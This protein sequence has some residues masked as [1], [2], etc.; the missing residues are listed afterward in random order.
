MKSVLM[1]CIFI[2]MGNSMFSQSE[3]LKKA[4]LDFKTDY[5]SGDYEKIFNNFS[6]EMQKALPLENAVQFFNGLKFQA[7]TIKE[8]EVLKIGDN[9]YTVYKTTFEKIILAV[10]IAIDSQN[11]I[12]GL[13]I[14]PYL[15]ETQKKIHNGLKKYPQEIGTAIFKHAKSFPDGTQLS[16]AIIKDGKEKYYGVKLEKDTLKP[17]ENQHKVFEIGSITK[18]F[19]A[20]VLAS[21]VV[22]GKLK[23]KDNVNRF[24]DFTFKD[25]IELS[26]LSLA[27]HTSGLPRLPENLDLSDENNP[28]K[29]YSQKELNEYLLKLMK[30]EN[31]SNTTYAYSNLGA[32][33]L[34]YTLGLS[35]KTSFNQLLQ[36]RIFD[37]YKMTNSFT[38]AN[39]LGDK[40]VKGLDENG[41][42]VQNWDFDVLFGGGGILSTTMD[43]VAFANA[44]FNIKNKELELTR[45]ATFEVNKN[46]KI[47]LGWHLLKTENDFNLVWHSGGTGG[48][49]SSMVLDVQK[50]NGIIILS[51]VSGLNPQHVEIDNLSFELMKLLE[52]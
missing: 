17:I 37:K 6:E 12:N 44:Q 24:Y 20:S 15:E 14:E 28:Y 29:N 48:Y 35:Q 21:L 18:V 38:S 5:N 40:L 50:L 22:D 1:I 10:N 32:G 34:G 45:K 49:S 46:M 16:I 7:G 47:G 2:L 33:L 31:Q 4:F 41:K 23:L 13:F 8:E 51:N 42:E 26:F 52:K 19:T 43:L 39:S 25:N 30:L 27:N 9:G 3:N 36:K 11:K